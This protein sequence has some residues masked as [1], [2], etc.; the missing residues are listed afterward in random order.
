MLAS[1]A[2]GE[3]RVCPRGIDN[4]LLFVIFGREEI[5]LSPRVRTCSFYFNE[6]LA[7]GGRKKHR[8]GIDNFLLFVIFGREEIGLSPRDVPTA[9]AGVPA[10]VR[11]FKFRRL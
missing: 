6:M 2:K 3:K 8:R 7:S 4:F 1:G 9:G 11:V 10:R 5:G